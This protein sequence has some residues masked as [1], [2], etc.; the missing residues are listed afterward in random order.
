MFQGKEFVNSRYFW[1]SQRG[2]A[3]RISTIG[4]LTTTGHTPAS[5]IRAMITGWEEVD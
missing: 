2:R 1:L 4:Y 5:H 3:D